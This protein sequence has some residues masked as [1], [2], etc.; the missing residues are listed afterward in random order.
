MKQHQIS[1]LYQSIS[2]IQSTI[3]AIDVKLGFLFVAVFLPV[4]AV[5]QIYQVYSGIKSI[6]IYDITSIVVLVF[7]CLSL[8]F[9]FKSL[10]SIKDP[11]SAISNFEQS[12]K[13]S[14]YNGDLFKLGKFELFFNNPVESKKS[15]SEKCQELPQDEDEIISS[16]MYES[17]KLSYIRDLKIERSAI[18]TCCI[19]L[20]ISIGSCIWCLSIFKV[21]L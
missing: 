14:F 15:I 13:C 7:W 10:I 21:G 9:L 5:P 17:F 18:C 11:V 16:L 20:S 12:E 3:R 6:A 2:D 4:V 19:F 8:Y 1:Y